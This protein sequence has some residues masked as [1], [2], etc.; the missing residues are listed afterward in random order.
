MD[1]ELD[2][3]QTGLGS[4]VKTAVLWDYLF[5]GNILNEFYSNFQ[6]RED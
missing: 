3:F 4:S 1:L 5:S 6:T 2:I